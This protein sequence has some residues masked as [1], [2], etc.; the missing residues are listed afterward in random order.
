MLLS[1]LGGFP[2]RS[3]VHQLPRPD[4][5]GS[6]QLQYHLEAGLLFAAFQAANEGMH[7]AHPF[8]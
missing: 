5:E 8:A 4:A 1:P 3:G 2:L 6:T 7:H